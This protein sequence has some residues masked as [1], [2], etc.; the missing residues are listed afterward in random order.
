MSKRI[1]TEVNM[2]EE[3][4]EQFRVRVALTPALTVFIKECN[5]KGSDEL[6]SLEW[7]QLQVW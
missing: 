2:A 5:K 1:R 7:E 6:S 4:S 3:T